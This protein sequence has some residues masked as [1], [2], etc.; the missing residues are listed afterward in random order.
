[1]RSTRSIARFVVFLK[2]PDAVAVVETDRRDKVLGIIR[3]H[4]VM[5][6]VVCYHSDN[7]CVSMIDLLNQ[8]PSKEVM[9]SK[10]V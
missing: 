8:I 9:R 3:Q 5:G 7:D 6:D 4:G 2:D 10:E 1:M